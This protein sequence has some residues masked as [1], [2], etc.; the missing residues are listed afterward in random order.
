MAKPRRSRRRADRELS[1]KWLAMIRWR[2]SSSKTIEGH[3]KVII[4]GEPEVEFENE[5]IKNGIPLLDSVVED[6]KSIGNKF[7]VDL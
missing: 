3:N 6:L 7:N 5:R 4:P 2:F 1:G